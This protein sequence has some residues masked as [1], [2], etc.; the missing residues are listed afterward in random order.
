MS[1]VAQDAV[2]WVASANPQKIAAAKI[3]FP[4][5]RNRVIG[6]KV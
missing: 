2:I 5:N 6:I 4:N 1:S 3:C